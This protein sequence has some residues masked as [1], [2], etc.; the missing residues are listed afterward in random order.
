[1][2][3]QAVARAATFL[4]IAA[5]APTQ[6]LAHVRHESRDLGHSA[7]KAWTKR[8]AVP[9]GRDLPV[10]IGLQQNDLDTAHHMLME[11]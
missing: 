2:H 1:M 8:S 9:A 11:T 5:A 6:L 3:F 4:A 7:T 10:R